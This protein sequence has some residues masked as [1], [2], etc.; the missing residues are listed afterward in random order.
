MSALCNAPAAVEGAYGCPR[1]KGHQGVCYWWLAWEVGYKNWQAIIYSGEPYERR[2]RARGRFS[3]PPDA[4]DIHMLLLTLEPLRKR[5]QARRT[6]HSAPQPTSRP[7]R[8]ERLPGTGLA[9]V[10]G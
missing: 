7:V 1:T 4:S 9:V 2:R 6:P 8:L 3:A 5:E 10:R